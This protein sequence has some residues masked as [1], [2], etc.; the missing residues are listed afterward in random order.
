VR[1]RCSQRGFADAPLSI[2]MQHQLQLWVMVR[3]LEREMGV[4]VDD[5]MVVR[6]NPRQVCHYPLNRWLRENSGAVLGLFAR[7]DDD[8]ATT[9]RGSAA[10]GARA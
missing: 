3:T 8:S 9:G 10:T 5:A 6:T 1:G 7:R 2:Y 4:R